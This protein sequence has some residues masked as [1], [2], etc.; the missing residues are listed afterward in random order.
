MEQRLP[1]PPWS[2][3]LVTFEKW[4]Y[5]AMQKVSEPVRELIQ[6][7]PI[8]ILEYPS[9]ELIAEGFDPR[10][11]V[12]FSGLPVHGASPKNSRERSSRSTSNDGAERSQ[13]IYI[14]IYKR[15]VER[16]VNSESKVIAELSTAL[17]G[18][19]ALFFSLKD[20]SISSPD[21][22]GSPRCPA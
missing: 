10:G 19:A 21:I 18:E 4:V 9:P 15:N 13:L 14:F 17:E 3:A 1:A 8:K 7:T 6:K 11:M 20:D 16:S 5:Q 2:S 12:F 22:G